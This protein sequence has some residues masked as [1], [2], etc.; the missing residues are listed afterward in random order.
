[1]QRM[2]WLACCQALNNLDGTL[3]GQAK[4][5][6]G[7]QVLGTRCHMRPLTQK[8]GCSNCNASEREPAFTNPAMVDTACYYVMVLAVRDAASI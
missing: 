1:M 6:E 4:E 8:V 2:L 3:K 5:A 7:D